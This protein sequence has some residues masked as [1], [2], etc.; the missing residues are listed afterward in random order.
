M[1]DLP[2]ELL[3]VVMILA[4]LGFQYLIKRFGPKAPQETASDEQGSQVPDELA[5]DAPVV[6][7]ASRVADG[8]F[9]QSA[10]HVVVPERQ[11]FSRSALLGSR[12]A[13]QNGVV[14]AT[15]LGPCRAFE[16]HDV[17]Q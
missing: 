3:Y 4:I 17:R 1:R 2:P 9:G 15:I 8:I 14:V 10:V 13:V 7:A 5:D 11:R 16:P 12:R 6:S